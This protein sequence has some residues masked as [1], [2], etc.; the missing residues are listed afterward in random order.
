MKKIIT[1]PGPDGIS[2]EKSRR[3]LLDYQRIL[4]HADEHK[5]D[6]DTHVA[7]GMSLIATAIAKHN[8]EERRRLYDWVRE[9]VEYL[10]DASGL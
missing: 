1:V 5:W 7:I 4:K 10:V 6:E 2:P 8:R 3:Q 9:E